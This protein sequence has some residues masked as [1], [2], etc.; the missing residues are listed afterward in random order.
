MRTDDYNVKPNHKE[1]GMAS[2]WFIGPLGS[3]EFGSGS[4]SSPWRTLSHALSHVKNIQ[5][6]SIEI[7]CEPG[8]Y[9]ILESPCVVELGDI[10]VTIQLAETSAEN[11]IFPA[12]PDFPMSS[13]SY[14]FLGRGFS[15]VTIRGS[16]NGGRL[17]FETPQTPANSPNF[18]CAI[19]SCFSGCLTIIGCEFRTL[20]GPGT[21]RLGL[22][23]T[24]DIAAM[25][26]AIYESGSGKPFED[27][28]GHCPKGFE[29]I[30]NYSLDT[31]QDE[32]LIAEITDCNFVVGSSFLSTLLTPYLAAFYGP[33][34]GAWL[35]N[36]HFT[37]QDDKAHYSTAIW[38]A[39]V[40]HLEV[41]H[42]DIE[43]VGQ[44]ATLVG[45]QDCTFAECDIHDLATFMLCPSVGFFKMAFLDSGGTVSKCRFHDYG[46]KS[47]LGILTDNLYTRK[48]PT[49]GNKTLLFEECSFNTAANGI[50]RNRKGIPDIPHGRE[51]CSNNV[52]F[53]RCYL[54]GHQR[55]HGGPFSGDQCGVILDNQN[56]S[57]TFRACVFEGWN[58]IYAIAGG[59]FDTDRIGMPLPP[60]TVDNCVFAE[61]LYGIRASGCAEDEYGYPTSTFDMTIRNTIFQGGNDVLHI[62]NGF[63]YPDDFH[64]RCNMFIDGPSDSKLGEA[65]VEMIPPVD[66]R[67]RDSWEMAGIEIKDTP[68]ET[69]SIFP[70][71]YFPV[72]EG[73]C[74]G[75]GSNE[76]TSRLSANHLSWKTHD[77]GAF[78]YKKKP[79][80][81]IRTAKNLAAVARRLAGH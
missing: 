39:E 7:T 17:A 67:D 33:G 32:R 1:T 56:Y 14:S 27:E 35:E 57:F 69:I 2:N 70:R 29:D 21:A 19:N 51:P 68:M 16:K 45:V 73:A 37:S 50:L 48:L 13:A 31:T 55:K 36:C 20:D 28:Q 12:G 44:A 15:D 76:S 54:N 41:S 61:S 64:A 42:T 77:R 24:S 38:A 66:D 25:T 22:A 60:L 30:P 78:A 53:D 18:V 34:V 80:L 23:C 43:K 47:D 46:G 4:I 10:D 40:G 79:N 59:H 74:H 58:H 3:D 75:T 26:K 11:A 63:V 9:P 81:V 72:K 52:I 71:K 5:E 49:R 6:G 8:V 65:M 62:Q